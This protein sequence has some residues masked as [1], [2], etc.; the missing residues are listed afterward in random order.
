LDVS[1]KKNEG[2]GGQYANVLKLG[3]IR[4]NRTLEKGGKEIIFGGRIWG[5]SSKKGKM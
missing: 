4:K 1:R 3:A 5:G 2:A